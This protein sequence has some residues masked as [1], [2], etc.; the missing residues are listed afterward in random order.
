MEV[1]PGAEEECNTPWERGKR[2]SHCRS[3]FPS[4]GAVWT[5]GV[6]Q[7]ARELEAEQVVAFGVSC[8]H[9]PGAEVARGSGQGR[10]GGQRGAGNLK[11][12]LGGGRQGA[13]NRD[14]HSAGAYVEGGG[15][16][17]KFFALFVAAAHENGNGEWQ[18]SPFPPLGLGLPGAHAHSFLLVNS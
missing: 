10:E 17:K 14:Q 2:F 1:I 12:D 18:S 6:Q 13:A 9:G 15:E 4:P 16:L 3:N 5:A 8:A 11:Q 7:W